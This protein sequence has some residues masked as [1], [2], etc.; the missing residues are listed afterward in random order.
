MLETSQFAKLSLR[1][2]FP[3]YGTVSPTDTYTNNRLTY[4]GLSHHSKII[5]T[6]SVEKG[7]NWLNDDDK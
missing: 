3:L 5:P 2:T 1:Q 4:V 6:H 7:Y